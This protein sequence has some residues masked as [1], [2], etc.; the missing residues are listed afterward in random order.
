MNNID[1]YI[2]ILLV[3]RCDDWGGDSLIPRYQGM[4]NY[5][6]KCQNLYPNLLEICIAEYN[7]LN[8]KAL[9]T[10]KV[11]IPP[12]MDIKIWMI[13]NEIHRLYKLIRPFYLSHAFNFLIRKCKGKFVLPTTQDLFFSESLIR[14]LS[15][16]VLKEKYFYRIDKLDFENKRPIKTSFCSFKDI[17]KIALLNAK[18]I[19]IRHDIRYPFISKDISCIEKFDKIPRSIK[20]IFDCY[21]KK[22]G[23]I[24]CRES[25]KNSYFMKKIKILKNKILE[26]LIRYNF[27]SSLN[28]IFLLLKD[29][30]LFGLHTNASGDFILA[31]REHYIAVGGFKED[32][33]QYHIDS[34]M[35]AQLAS[36]GLKQ[37]ILTDK[38]LLYNTDHKRGKES[39]DYDNSRNWN[40]V[41]MNIKKMLNHEISYHLNDKNWG[42]KKYLDKI[43]KIR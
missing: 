10:K 22:N 42:F 27:L 32:K 11:K 16:K 20:N 18:R 33:T 13:P 31:S 28:K 37:I 26:I 34:Y 19:H 15:K 43:S 2:S 6:Y 7:P 36:K 4:I 21:D 35:V 3:V 38:H 1:P 9:F 30:Y 41:Y 17:D 14:F 39:I 24:Y 29:S 12:E 25:F 23:L 8:N 5:L 40:K